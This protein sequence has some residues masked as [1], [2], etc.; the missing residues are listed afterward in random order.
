MLIDMAVKEDS[1]IEQAALFTDDFPPV[2][3]RITPSVG[4]RY[5]DRK[6]VT[7]GVARN[8]DIDNIGEGR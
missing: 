4:T 1:S 6:A 3:I 5:G 8:L 7:H 2:G